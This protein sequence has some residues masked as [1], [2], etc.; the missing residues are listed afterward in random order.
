MPE[1]ARAVPLSPAA[2]VTQVT[3]VG[4]TL[5]KVLVGVA[6]IATLIGGTVI[7]SLM[8]IAVSERR[9]EIGIRRAVGASRRDIMVQFLI[10]A[11]AVAVL[12]G[13]VGVLI[14][15]AITLLIT[16]LGELSPAI[17]WSAV[18]GSVL[19]SAGIGLVFGLQPAWRAANIDPIEALRS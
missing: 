8:L 16:M 17:M 4:S 5:S 2:Q 18:G 1:P 19:L 14:G 10:E 9:R 12:G 6:V 15:V 11:A 13:I 3:E 7:M